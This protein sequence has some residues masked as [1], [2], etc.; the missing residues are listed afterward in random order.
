MNSK[1]G[2]VELSVGTI[3]IVVLAMSMLILGLVLVNKIMCSAIRGIDA[4]DEQMMQEMRRL[5][6]EQRRIVLKHQENTVYKGLRE[7][8][9]VAFGVVNLGKT[10]PDFRYEVGISDI[11]NCR[12]SESRALD[13]I[14]LGRQGRM[15]ISSGDDYF[16][17]MKF[18]I[19]ADV[20]PCQLRYLI[21][22]YN[23]GEVYASAP[24][25]VVI[26]ERPFTRSFC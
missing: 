9:G 8:Y 10:S 22:V 25:N 20:E 14:V 26:S 12:F 1:R 17:L 4:V 23:D 2:A 6:G 5:F 21:T 24:V 7:G 15:S 19:P 13:F 11:G 3:V 16:D 18:E